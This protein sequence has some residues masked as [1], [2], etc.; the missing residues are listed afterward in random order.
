MKNEISTFYS[1]N[2]PMQHHFPS[3]SP[4]VSSFSQNRIHHKFIIP[5]GKSPCRRKTWFSVCVC[6]CV[7]G[8][9]RFLWVQFA[10]QLIPAAQTD[11]QTRTSL[12]SVSTDRSELHSSRRPQAER[13]KHSVRESVCLSAQLSPAT[14]T[15]PFNWTTVLVSAYKLWRRIDL[16]SNS[17]TAGSN[18]P[19][20]AGW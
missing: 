5:P 20:S 15:D 4:E 13:G 10:G 14:V 1:G 6:V 8:H 7:S 18:M 9:I 16:L 11:R 12:G 2:G 19:R 17:A 3:V